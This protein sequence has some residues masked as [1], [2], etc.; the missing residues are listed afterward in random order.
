MERDHEEEKLEGK[1]ESYWRLKKAPAA[2]FACTGSR[3]IQQTRKGKKR[4]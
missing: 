1:K 2:N 3:Q 4:M